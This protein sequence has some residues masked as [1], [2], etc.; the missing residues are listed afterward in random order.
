ME[1]EIWLLDS[2]ATQGLGIAPHAGA[3]GSSPAADYAWLQGYTRSV[4]ERSR[5]LGPNG[6]VLISPGGIYKG[7]HRIFQVSRNHCKSFRSQLVIRVHLF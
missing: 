7:V 2:S 4:L 5:V 1:T 6:T 3:A